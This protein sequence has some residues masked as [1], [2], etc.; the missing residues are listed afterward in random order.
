MRLTDRHAWRSAWNMRSG[1]ACFEIAY[2]AIGGARYVLRFELELGL[3]QHK[4]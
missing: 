3:C 2:G 4:I 1:L